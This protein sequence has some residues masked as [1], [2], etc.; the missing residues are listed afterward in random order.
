MMYSKHMENYNT[1]EI[2]RKRI[3]KEKQQEKRR[4]N[5]RRRMI[6]GA[7]VLVLALAS[8]YFL[9][10]FIGGEVYSSYNKEIKT[11]MEDVPIVNVAKAQIG[12]VGGEP[13]WSWYGFDSRVE[14]CACFASWCENELGYI[15]EEKA[16][17]FAMVGDGIGWFIYQDQWLQSDATPAAGD[18]IFFDWDQDDVRDHV[19]IVSSVVGDKVFAIEG[20]SSDRCRVKSYNLGDPVIYGYGHISV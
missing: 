9:G 19:G 1:D 15:E 14:W 11:T 17:K 5:K 6:S 16:P 8:A 4:R 12:N 7:I 18:L 13:Y 10:K 2:I 20:N 3:L